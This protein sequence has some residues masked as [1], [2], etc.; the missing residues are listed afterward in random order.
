MTPL[1]LARYFLALGTTGFG[2]PIALVGY[3]QRDLVEKR[4]WFTADEL[5]SGL[6]LAQ[7]SPGPLA[8]QLALY[9]GW[10]RGGV[11]GATLA[12]VA[13][14]APSFLMVLVISALYVRYGELPWLRGAFTAV[15]AAVVGILAR[16]A[17]KLARMTLARDPLLWSLA[18]ANAVAVLALRRESLL[19]LVASGAIAYGWRAASAGHVARALAPL[20][21][22][23]PHGAA[24]ALSTMPQLAALFEYFAVA[25]VAVF[26][27]G[28]AIVPYLFHGVVEQHGWLTDRQFLDAIAVSMVTPGPVVITVAFIGYLVAGIP[29][30]VV[31]AVGVFLPVWLVVVVVAPYFDRVRR[32]AGARRF[33]DGITAGATGAIGGAAALLSARVLTDAPAVAIAVVVVLATATR[34][35]VPEPVAIAGAGLLGVLLG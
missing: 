28:L 2:G 27:S 20:W 23:A 10:R 13:F 7:M 18:A 5:A 14:I 30:A 24:A 21:L 4:G 3:M 33:I 9:L 19:I 29:G 26:G 11:F 15:G 34:L 17:F 31:S 6:A 32:N 1:A 12:G 35:R 8:A 16:S 22:L 25:G